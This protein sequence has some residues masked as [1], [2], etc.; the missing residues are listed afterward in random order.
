MLKRPLEFET[1]S[2]VYVATE[3]IGQ[4]DASLVYG[5]TAPD[6]MDVAIKVLYSER[7]S[8]DKRRRFKNEL[9]FLAR[10]RHPNI[11]TVLDHGVERSGKS[12][13]PFYVMRRYPGS[14]RTAMTKGLPQ[15]QVLPLLS[16]ILDGVEAA[17]LQGVIHR[18]IKPENVLV[19]PD[20][21][22][23]AVADF[24]VARFTEDLLVTL[25]ETSAAQRLANFQYAAPEQR[26]PGRE[27]GV[28]ADIYALGLLINEL[29][30]GTVPHGTDY[31]QIATAS[32]DHSYLDPIVEMMLRQ[33]PDKRPP[34]IEALKVLIQRY[35][36]E[37][38][39][40]Q[41]LS[42]LDGTVIPES[43]IDE[44]LADEP[45]RLIAAEWNDGRLF[46]TLDKPVSQAWV[47]AL[48]NMG[49]YSAAAGR[50]PGT[51]S[52]NGRK[53]NVASREHD[54]QDIINYFRQ[55]LPVASRTLKYTL[56]QEARKKDEAQ[57]EQLRKERELEETRL[58]VNRAL[59]V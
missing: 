27:V 3:L 8:T 25:V 38:V 35:Q 6:N 9:F 34:S 19:D 41:R 47:R 43:Q 13:K 18:D 17:H 24:G 26:V 20:I 22:A 12:S 51:F 57:R 55:W 45:P 11:V 21:N 39:T 48:Q 2:G 28:P 30:T 10:N 33:S 50:G 5:G 4:G 1:A 40:L 16:Q 59:K 52:F 54:A 37:S 36:V 14:L 31:K 53:A 29:F 44:P 56:Q 46:L 32:N 7:A 49:N 15:Q 58:R 23:V 42:A